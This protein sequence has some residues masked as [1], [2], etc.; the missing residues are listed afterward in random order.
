M[1]GDVALAGRAAG[2]APVCHLCQ[3]AGI[4][5]EGGRLMKSPCACTGELVAE[6]VDLLA[7]FSNVIVELHSW[8]RRAALSR[9]EIPLTGVDVLSI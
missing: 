6:L 1:N 9:S 5:N 2:A 8:A 3:E 7:F 4:D